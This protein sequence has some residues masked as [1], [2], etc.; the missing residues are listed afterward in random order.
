MTLNT[1]ERIPSSL[2]IAISTTEQL[3]RCLFNDDLSVLLNKPQNPCFRES[4]T[5]PRLPVRQC[6]PPSVC[7]FRHL[8]QP[9]FSS[10]KNRSYFSICRKTC[11]TEIEPYPN[12]AID[13]HRTLIARNPFVAYNGQ[14]GNG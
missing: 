12:A 3:C 9:C 2:D 14:N 5:L 13:S 7:T 1:G 8:V 11:L 4:S 6:W 10:S